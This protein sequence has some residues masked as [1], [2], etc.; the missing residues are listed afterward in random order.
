MVRILLIIPYKELIPVM[1]EYVRKQ[2][3]KDVEI[4][5]IHLYGTDADLKKLSKYQLVAARGITGMYI[6]NQLPQINVVEI[7]MTSDDVVTAV[8]TC[9]RKN[10]RIKTAVI[11]PENEKFRLDLLAE[12]TGMD[13]KTYYVSTQ[14]EVHN[15]I[16]AVIDEKISSIIGGLTVY[17]C[18]KEHGLSPIMLK[19]GPEAIMRTIQIALNGAEVLKRE[20]TRANL[21]T[22]IL[23][24]GRD[25]ML[26]LDKENFVIIANTEAEHLFK[27]END[28]A[29][30]LAGKDVKQIIPEWNQFSP[31]DFE[32]QQ[33]LFI[34]VNGTLI[35][36]H[37]TPIVMDTQVIGRL[38]TLQNADQIREYE[39][40]IRKQLSHKGMAAKYTFRNI[41]GK[42]AAIKTCIDNAYKYSQTN[43]NVLIIGEPG[44]GKELFAQSIHNASPRARQPFVAVNCAA[45]PEQLLES[46]LFGYS[47]GAFT[48]AAKGGKLGL[49]ELAHKGSIFLDEIGE[50]PLNLQAK[51]LRVLQEKEI[52]RIGDDKVIPIDVRVLSATNV[53]MKE[54]ISKGEFRIDLYYRIN[55]LNLFIPPLRERREDIGVLFKHFVNSY[56]LKSKIPIQQI[57]PDALTML[58]HF[59][60]LGNA[61]ELRNFSE[62]AVVLCEDGIIDKAYIEHISKYD[63]DLLCSQ[64]I[65]EEQTDPTV[66]KK[67]IL[68]KENPT[69]EELAKELGISRTTLWRRLKENK[70]HFI[71]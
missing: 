63:H 2:H 48:G 35:L 56:S 50:M 49:F 26:A 53:D 54:K 17:R 33:D 57:T 4:D 12:L 59:V 24:S 31:S 45:L 34:H 61:R 11:L 43:Y 70:I 51:L 60:W 67:A 13:L 32:N 8:S 52:R 19:T 42:G 6:K 38:L 14:E 44:T 37:Q 25:A 40:T 71:D 65:N 69:K 46:E 20:Y 15:V 23:N 7:P 36:V 18:C 10:G 3:V 5:I 28:E 29:Q 62:R 66:Y 1:R 21:M 30:T 16:H 9:V 68:I 27:N 22:T 55:I 41:L 64:S 39:T 47:D 58:H